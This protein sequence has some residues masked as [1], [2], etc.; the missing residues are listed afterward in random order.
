MDIIGSA[1]KAGGGVTIGAKTMEQAREMFIINVIMP[2]A[3]WYD[4][5]FNTDVAWRFGSKLGGRH[6]FSSNIILENR[7]LERAK[8]AATLIDRVAPLN[9]VVEWL[10]LKL[11][12]QPHGDEFWITH[13]RLWAIWTL[14]H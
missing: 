9:E 3:E 8:I 13:G 5:E 7:R 6:D 2:W 10:D 12:K 4:N 14:E 1:E 11:T